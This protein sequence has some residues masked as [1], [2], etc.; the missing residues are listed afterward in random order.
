MSIHSSSHAILLARF[1]DHLARQRYCQTI[2][3]RYLTVADN[4]LR[5]LDSRAIPIELTAPVHISRYLHC[6]LARFHDI[7]GHAP[8]STGHWRNSHTSGIRC[9]LRSLCGAWPPVSHTRTLPEA[10]NQTVAS[11]AEFLREDRGLAQ[12]T[13]SGLVRECTWFLEWY[14]GQSNS[15]SLLEMS[16]KDVD[17]YLL[18][19][20]PGLRRISRKGVCMRLRCFM[21][22]VHSMGATR[23]D[24]STSILAP[25]IYT[26]EAIPSALRPGEITTILEET[27]KDRSPKGLRDYSILMLLSTYG[28][29]AG[30]IARL[31]LD[32][33]DW[34][35]DRLTVHHSKTNARTILPLMPAVGEALLAYLRQGRPETN[36]REIFIRA[37]APYCGFA[38]GSSLYT[39]IRRRIE[40]AGVHPAGKRGPHTFRHARAVSLLR[41]EVPPKIIGDLLGHRSTAS[42]TPYLKLA[43]ED[44]RAVALEIPGWGNRS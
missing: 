11:Y 1:A 26:D 5:Y 8:I 33:I 18:Y 38:S 32:D 30:E 31:R 28:L 14:R 41:G 9:F 7:H 3:E 21:R 17:D 15:D 19:R 25:T 20:V 35:A 4:F 40:Q 29:R 39:P 27:R 10:L 34:H 24:F 37:R 13:I 6:E 44:L 23:C 42:T 43:V 2:S 22:F 36:L 12:K 16:I